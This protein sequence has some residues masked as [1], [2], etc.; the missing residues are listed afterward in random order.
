MIKSDSTYQKKIGKLRQKIDKLDSKIIQLLNERF[1]IVHQV[2]ALKKD[3]DKDI[4]DPKREETIFQRLAE[5]NKKH[6][7][8]LTDENVQTIYK[9]IISCAKHAEK[10]IIN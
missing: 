8:K 4:H 3:H 5:L 10:E 9:T 1:E 2:G 6:G 7:K